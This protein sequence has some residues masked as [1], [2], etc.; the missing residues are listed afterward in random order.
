MTEASITLPAM[1]AAAQCIGSAEFAS[2]R[3]RLLATLDNAVGLVTAG[4]PGH[5]DG[6]FR[7]HAD[8]EYLTGVADEPGAMLLLDPTNPDARRRSMLFLKPLNRER[9]RW[10]GYRPEI[11]AALRE[12]LGIEAIF[13]TDT[14]GRALNGAVRRSR[15]MACLHAPSVH[16][17]PV[18]ADLAIFRKVAERIPGTTIEDRGE[19]LAKMRSVKSPQEVALIQHAID[20]T[21]VG[22]KAMLRSA[23]PG[24]GEGD[25]QEA[26]EHAYRSHGSRNS[27]FATIVGSGVNSTVL[28]YVA[29]DQTLED[30]DLVCVDSGAVFGGYAADVTRTVPVSGTFSKRQRE[31]YEVVLEAQAAAIEAI[32]PGATFTELDDAARNVIAGA[33]YGDYFIHS[34]GH[35][36]GL[37]THDATPDGPLEQGAV[38]TIEP[39]IY[40]PDEKIGVRIEDDVLVTESGS[41]VL[42]ANIPKRVADVEEAMKKSR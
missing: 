25:V 23:S 30:G 9:E 1:N 16:T 14:L 24:V 10:D 8:F 11:S 27:A 35:H 4:D 33:G 37:E 18:S 5:G 34:I 28:H 7:P 17:Q 22:F 31:I 21:S 38:V 2:R 3:D 41:K 12:R 26:I 36:L 32:R 42:S 6:V 40:I 19:T 39:G 29:N 13:R 15:R 20:I